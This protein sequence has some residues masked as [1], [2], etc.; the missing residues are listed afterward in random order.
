MHLGFVKV[1]N[2]T[3]TA[4]LD[5]W[6]G[7]SYVLPA[8]L[9]K[10]NTQSEEAE[11]IETMM[12]SIVRKIDVFEVKVEGVNV[13]FQIN[14]E[15]REVSTIE[16]ETLLSLTYPKCEVVLKQHQH[17]PNIKMIH[18]YYNFI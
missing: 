10:K 5:T 8:L 11:L 17:L 18:Y 1:K 2:I 7:S 15:V 14:A 13:S 3:Y 4:P 12:H 6:D 9:E 16:S